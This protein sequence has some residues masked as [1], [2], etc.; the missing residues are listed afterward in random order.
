MCCVISSIFFIGPRAGLLIWWLVN[1]GRFHMVYSNL[2]LPI[3]GTIFLPITT[4]TYTFVFK[5]SYGGLAS[6]DWL[7]MGIAL[8]VDMSL[9]GGGVFSRRRR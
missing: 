3:I 7:L 4:L 5:S 2:L 8:L 6:L 1:P 9:Y